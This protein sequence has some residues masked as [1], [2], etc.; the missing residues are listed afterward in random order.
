VAAWF[1]ALYLPPP[2]GADR[3]VGVKSVIVPTSEYSDRRVV[4]LQTSRSSYKIALS[5]LVEQ[6]ADWSWCG[7]HVLK[8]QPR[9]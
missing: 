6:R 9:F 7:I 4:R 1:E 8:K 3:S 5:T 2:S